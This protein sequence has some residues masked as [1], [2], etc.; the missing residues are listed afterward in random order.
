MNTLQWMVY[1]MAWSAS[2]LCHA[3]NSVASPSNGVRSI[4]Q[5]ARLNMKPI[6]FN[7][8][9]TVALGL[10]WGEAPGFFASMVKSVPITLGTSIGMGLSIQSLIDRLMYMFGVRVE[11]PRLVPPTNGKAGQ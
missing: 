8:M 1:L 5:W 6:V 7:L 10:I 2:Y 11:M 9:F 4:G 3:Q